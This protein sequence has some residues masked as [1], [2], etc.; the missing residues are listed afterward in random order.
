MRHVWHIRLMRYLARLFIS[1]WVGALSQA[2]AA[3]PPLPSPAPVQSTPVPSES[4]TAAA[5]PLAANAAKTEV[6]KADDLAA[7][8]KRLRSQG[9]K[10]EVHS[11]RTVFCRKETQLGSRF[12]TKLCGTTDELDKAALYGMEVTEAIQRDTVT[13]QSN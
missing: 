12:E 11:G 6:P 9:Y 4:G 1:L 2:L 8:T 13:R 3:E 7:Q 10:P 5:T